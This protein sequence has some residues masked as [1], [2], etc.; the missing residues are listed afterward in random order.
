MT[1]QLSYFLD[2]VDNFPQSELTFATL[3]SQKTK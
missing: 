1:I 2:N 3:F